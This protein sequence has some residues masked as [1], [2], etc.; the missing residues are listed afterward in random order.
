M[1]INH[2]KKNP[3]ATT[4]QHWNLRNTQ[5]TK[6]GSPDFCSL[7]TSSHLFPATFSKLH[8][9]PFKKQQQEVLWR[10]F[11]CPMGVEKEGWGASE[12]GRHQQPTTE[13]H[14]ESSNY[15][16]L[17]ICHNGPERWRPPPRRP[18]RRARAPCM[19]MTHTQVL[20]GG[21]HF[22]SRRNPGQGRK[23]EGLA[24]DVFTSFADGILTFPTRLVRKGTIYAAT[25]QS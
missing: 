24:P 19:W 6:A 11:K 23:G 20:A 22:K 8:Q 16:S 15:R 1:H 13:R 17:G 12:R 14:F 5:K 10:G 9:L 18:E 25:Q 21:A 2:R 3:T 7:A 4:G